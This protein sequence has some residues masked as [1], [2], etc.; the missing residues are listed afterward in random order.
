[1]PQSGSGPRFP[2]LHFVAIS[3]S[4]T[5]HTHRS[6][7]LS[8]SAHHLSSNLKFIRIEPEFLMLFRHIAGI[9]IDRCVRCVATNAKHKIPIEKN[10][11]SRQRLKYRQCLVSNSTLEPT[12]FSVFFFLCHCKC[13]CATRKSGPSAD[14]FLR[15]RI[16][17]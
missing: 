13:S 17:M 15:L 1:M 6:V 7:P 9:Y 11:K 5:T 3:S 10:R 12:F 14:L 4:C 8:S 16:R 2:R